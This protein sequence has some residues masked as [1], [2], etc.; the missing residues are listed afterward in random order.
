[1][2]LTACQRNR[3]AIET[4]GRHGAAAIMVQQDELSFDEAGAP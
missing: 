1:V 2:A 3:R 4:A